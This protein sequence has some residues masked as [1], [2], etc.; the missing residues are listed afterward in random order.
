MLITDYLQANASVRGDK[1]AIVF[2][3][4]TVSGTAIRTSVTW[5][6]FNDMSDRV[7]KLI[8]RS[9]A[10]K[11]DKAAIVLPNCLEWLPIYLGILKAGA[12]AV[13]INSNNSADEIKYCLELSD[14]VCAFFMYGDG[15]SDA[16]VEVG[17]LTSVWYLGEDVPEH[18]NDLMK[19][20][21]EM[22]VTDSDTEIKETDVAVIYFS[23]G[24]TGRSKAV[25]LSHKALSC[26]AVTE[27]SHHMQEQRDNFLCVA[28]F[29]HTGA[30]VHWLGTLAVGGCVVVNNIRSPKKI[31]EIIESEKVGIAWLVV[32]QIQD[33][34][35]LIDEG[36]IRKECFASMRLM[37]TGAQPIPRELM[38]RWRSMFPAM[39][40][41][42]S[43]GLT[44]ATGP[45]CIDMGIDTIE[46][47]GSIGK[48]ARGWEAI[49]VDSEDNKLEPYAV[50][51][52]FLRGPGV[53]TGYY[54]DAE[55]TESVLRGGWLHT[56]DMVYK[57]CD[58]Y[59]YLVDRKKDVIIVGGENVYPVQ[60][61]NF[62]R[63]FEFVKDA[64][65]IGIPNPRMGESVA[66]IIELKS[67]YR[68]SKSEIRKLCSELPE[69]Q[70]PL[71]ILFDDIIRNTTGKINRAAM[72]ARYL[73]S[74]EKKQ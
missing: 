53:M 22:P 70:R 33:I 47:L 68:C 20:L 72:R 57:D 17:S 25:M 37:H 3:G 40:I 64:A 31:S 18:K 21:A 46:K 39:S 61:E 11:G 27:L 16:A 19:C 23:S 24:T 51:E 5:N 12:V 1:K 14:C 41:D 28:P 29:Y 7:A 65:V 54:K 69:Y 26:G 71:R 63:Q 56:G 74:R 60:L 35:D 36:V 13:P 44:E 32:P 66:V 67:G 62:F 55:A 4:K 43:Y 45:G 73:S 50:G 8:K 49:V 48:L 9:G 58:G 30:M 38:M 34:L 59:Y 42:V 6:E 15:I 52:L 10:K 2:I